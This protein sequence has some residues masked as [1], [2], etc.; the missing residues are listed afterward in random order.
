MGLPQ[1]VET[2][3]PPPVLHVRH[4]LKSDSS[5]TYLGDVTTRTSART[6][7]LADLAVHALVAHRHLQV[8]SRLE[9]GAEWQDLD[10]VFPNGLGG[11]SDAHNVRRSLRKLCLKAEVP[12]I[13]P[14]AMRHTAHTLFSA[15]HM[16]LN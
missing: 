10:L 16:R 11:F 8:T 15:D 1:D 2:D 4:C 6:V 12:V 14:Y 3:L 5:G 13:T 9:L 7:P